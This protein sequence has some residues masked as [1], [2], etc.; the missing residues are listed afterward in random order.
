[1]SAFSPLAWS[2]EIKDEEFQIS[3]GDYSELITGLDLEASV[4]QDGEPS[5]TFPLENPLKG[6]SEFTF[7]G[8]FPFSSGE[9]NQKVMQLLVEDLN[10]VGRVINMNTDKG[11]DLT[12]FATCAFLDF[13]I[14]DIAALSGKELPVTSATLKLNVR[15][16]LPKTENFCDCDV[17]TST[18][19]LEG[20]L[21]NNKEEKVAQ[22]FRYLLKKFKEDFT[23]ANPLLKGGPTFYVY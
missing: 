2:Q 8:N 17:W 6:F 12:G 3:R 15:T 1:M 21:Q 23:A 20:A 9:E 22:A 11:I 19:F 5:K 13:T 4:S 10:R 16:I 18:C 14:G 7:S